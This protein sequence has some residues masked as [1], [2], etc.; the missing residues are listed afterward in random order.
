MEHWGIY[1]E[2]KLGKIFDRVSC[3]ESGRIGAEIGFPVFDP[4]RASEVDETKI[5]CPVLVI[6]SYK[7]KVTPD[8]IARNVAKKFLPVSD[9]KEYPTFG[10][11]YMTGKEFSIVFDHCLL[12]IQDNLAKN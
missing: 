3:Y 2:Q 10:Y 5:K 7:D 12:W 1:L 6:G 11:W 8:R 4:C 9:Y